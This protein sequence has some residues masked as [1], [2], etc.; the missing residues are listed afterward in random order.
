MDTSDSVKEWSKERII[1]ALESHLQTTVLA[2]LWDE[3]VNNGSTIAMMS[4][5][6]ERQLSGP[7]MD[8]CLNNFC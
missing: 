1:D 5:Q 2:S 6:M 8:I 4:G 3:M 7:V